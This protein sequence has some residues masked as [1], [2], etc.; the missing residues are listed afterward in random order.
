MKALNYTFLNLKSGTVLLGKENTE[1]FSFSNSKVVK[2][3]RW[4]CRG[5]K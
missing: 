2:K 4:K 3:R 1:R 5:F